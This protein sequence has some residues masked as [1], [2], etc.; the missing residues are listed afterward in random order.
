MAEFQRITFRI[1][2]EIHEWLK[3]RAESNYRSHNAEMIEQLKQSMSSDQ[4]AKEGAQQ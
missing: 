3:R 2:K 4:Q 1:P